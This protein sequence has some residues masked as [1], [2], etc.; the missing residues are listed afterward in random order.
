MR[1]IYCLLMLFVFQF[2]FSQSVN[3]SI[4]GR[5]T[6]FFD[7][8]GHSKLYKATYVSVP[9]IAGGLIVK[10]EDDD[11][12]KMRSSYLPRFHSHIDD[13]TQYLPAAVMLARFSF[14]CP[15]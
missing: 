14:S 13:F 1:L 3:D 5:N 11:F 10:N 15:G 12:R 6:N 7:R 4:P 2:T 9:L 8:M